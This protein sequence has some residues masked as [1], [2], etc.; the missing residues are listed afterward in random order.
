MG[1]HFQKSCAPRGGAHL[2]LVTGIIIDHIDSFF[3][4][5]LRFIYPPPFF[6]FF[7]FFFCRHPIMTVFWTC[8]ISEFFVQNL[9]FFMENWHFLSNSQW[10][11]LFVW[12]ND[13]FLKKNWTSHQKDLAI[14]VLSRCPIIPVTSKVEC[15]PS[16]QYWISPAYQFYKLSLNVKKN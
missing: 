10:L 7:I 5:A 12:S 8:R 15:P 6:L 3:K 4:L 14:L 16:F 11:T 9:Y 1:G 2:K 13:P